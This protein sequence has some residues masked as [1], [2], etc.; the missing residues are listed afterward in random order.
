ME[1]YFL[2]TRMCAITTAFLSERQLRNGNNETEEPN[3]VSMRHKWTPALDSRL[4]EASALYGK[5]WKRVA[6]H[7]GHSK[8]RSQCQ[9]RWSVY[10][11]P[12]EEEARHDPQTTRVKTG[13]WTD[14]EITQLQQ[15]VVKHRNTKHGGDEGTINWVLV[16]Q[17]AG[18]AYKEC[19]NKWKVL[20]APRGKKGGFTP[21][22]DRLVAERVAAWGSKGPGLWTSLERD[23]GRRG[24]SICRRWQNVLQHLVVEAGVQETSPANV[25]TAKGELSP[26][27]ETEATVD[28][29]VREEEKEVIFEEV[30]V[31]PQSA[32]A[33]KE[34]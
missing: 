2:T 12:Q 32:A 10:V 11:G 14:E 33:E 7:V 5:Q 24:K 6:E 31:S 25:S 18:R 30:V 3:A 26:V 15:L 19:R 1:P 8:D 29:M 22:E 21:D 17:E 34:Q 20:S 28:D 27:L 4:K 9:H 13:P 16:A 23:I